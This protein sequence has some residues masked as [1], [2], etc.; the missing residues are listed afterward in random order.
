LRAATL[1]PDAKLAA[2]G[3]VLGR[4]RTFGFERACGNRGQWRPR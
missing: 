3:R 1:A 2:A 4:A